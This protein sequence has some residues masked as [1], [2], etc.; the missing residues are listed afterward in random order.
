M[1]RE[2]VLRGLEGHQ[3]LARGREVFLVH[4]VNQRPMAHAPNRIDSPDI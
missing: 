3:R 2:E 1:K 4:L